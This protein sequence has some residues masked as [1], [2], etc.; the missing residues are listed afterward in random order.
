MDLDDLRTYLGKDLEAVQALMLSSLGS[1][2]D[3][4]NKANDRIFSHSGKQLRPMLTLLCA[5]ACSM[6]H[7]TRDTVSFAAASEL[8]HNATLLHDDV[9]DGGKVRRGVP[10]VFALLGGRPSV[11][12]G[13]YWLVKAM[14]RILGADNDVVSVIKLFSKTL[15]DLAEGE[16]FQLQKADSGDTNENDYLRI[17]FCKT[18]SLFRASAVS[19]AI[20]VSAGKEKAGTIAEYADSI[21]YAFQIK[22]DIFDYEGGASSIGKPVGQDLMERKI[23]IPLLGAFRNA[24][25]EKERQVRSMVRN[26]D[27]HPEYKEQILGFVKE[28]RGIE[29]AA[30]RLDDFVD[31]AIM[32]LNSLPDG[33]DKD[34]LVRLAIFVG[35][36]NK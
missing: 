31:T 34:W 4:L 24:G 19:G 5:R 15:S 20:S 35:E 18:G 21:G 13:D 17:I 28:Y 9:A 29:Y 8:L 2:I 16:L 22:D 30:K 36:R 33:P 32:R 1:D 27:S 26:L 3:I 6:G 10:T 25:A 23:T 7:V 14:E 11:L 12:L